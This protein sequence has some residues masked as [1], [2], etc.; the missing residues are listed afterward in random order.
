M[1]LPREETTP[2]VMNTYRAMGF[3]GYL[4]FIDSASPN[5]SNPEITRGKRGNR[6]EYGQKKTGRFWPAG[7]LCADRD[8]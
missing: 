8:Y 3:T 1:P 7:V 2:P 6:P 5:F 4:H